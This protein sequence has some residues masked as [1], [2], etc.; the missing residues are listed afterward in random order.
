MA[1]FEIV[2]RRVMSDTPTCFFLNPSFQSAYNI[3]ASNSNVSSQS[4]H[5]QARQARQ[6][7]CLVPS[8]PSADHSFSSPELQRIFFLPS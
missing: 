6:V 8:P 5:L 4:I 7:R 1:S 2:V 3:V